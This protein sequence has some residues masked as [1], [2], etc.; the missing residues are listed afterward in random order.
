MKLASREV[1]GWNL[2]VQREGET[3]D[4]RDV[5]EG[6]SK[7]AREHTVAADLFL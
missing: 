7:R 2:K 1:D 4:L 5:R 3:F 6:S